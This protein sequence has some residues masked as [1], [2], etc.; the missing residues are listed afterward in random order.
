MRWSPLVCCLLYS[1]LALAIES[2]GARALVHDGYRLQEL[3]AP[4]ALR[5]WPQGSLAQAAACAAMP[6]APPARAGELEVVPLVHDRFFNKFFQGGGRLYRL[7]AQQ[8]GVPRAVV[9]RSG[10]W[11]LPALAARLSGEKDVL[12]RQGQTYLLRM[13]VLL[14]A[15]T[16]LMV[17]EGETLRLSRNRGSFLISMGTLHL[18]KAHIEAWDETRGAQALPADDTTF[19][20]FLL[21][22]SGSRTLLRDSTLS[23]L[24]FNEGLAKGLTLATG[25]MGLAGYDLPAPPQA[26]IQGSRFE[27]MYTGIQATGIPALEVCGNQFEASRQHAL[28]LEEGSGGRLVRN[29]ITQTEG[30]YAVYLNKGVQQ[31]RIVQNEIVENRRSGL[32]ISSSHD[33]VI[34]DNQIRQNYDAIFLED[35]D[36]VLLLDNHVLDNQRHG[37]S[38]RNVG[39]VRFQGDHIGPNRGVGI[40]AQPAEKTQ[41]TR[42]GRTVAGNAS[43]PSAAAA[44]G[45]ASPQSVAYVPAGAGT[46]GGA[47]SASGAGPS[48][49][50]ASVAVTNDARSSD[51]GNSDAGARDAG[52]SGE[53]KS[54]APPPSPRVPRVPR[55]EMVNVA[56]EGNHSSALAVE[57][58]YTIVLHR[59]DVLYPGVRRRPVFRGVL[60]SFESDILDRLA[61]RKTLLV[62]PTATSR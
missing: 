15:G 5:Q 18:R 45:Q 38:L 23:G 51:A 22:W 48:D 20:P 24:G 41:P 27:G 60:N 7:V 25:P 34:A 53:T 31:L 10:N 42:P 9:I 16:A 46:P 40:L 1:P 11:T 21:G 57:R 39:R 47:P 12:R 43:A 49:A 4:P 6:A 52:A 56:L 17:S 29:R 61:E 55:L 35:V 3:S 54:A 37:V 50:R 33:I 62:A 32:A 59:I 44:A 36:D 14:Q 13:P 8:E 2:A 19:Q 28:H 30:P 26:L 58:P